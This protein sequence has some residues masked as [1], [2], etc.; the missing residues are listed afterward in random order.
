[1]AWQ[2]PSHFVPTK[3]VFDSRETQR[4]DII[5]VILLMN[6]M[7]VTRCFMPLCLPKGLQA[8][9][10]PELFVPTIFHNPQLCY[11]PI[12][13][14][15]LLVQIHQ[16]G[17]LFWPVKEDQTIIGSGPAGHLLVAPSLDS[18]PS[19]YPHSSLLLFQGLKFK[20]LTCQRS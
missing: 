19:Q 16:R 18:V 4:T 2:M 14:L 15:I 12:A 5:L 20:I 6:C 9:I 7:F 17:M 11:V 3:P 1:M 8:E 13:F 10:Q